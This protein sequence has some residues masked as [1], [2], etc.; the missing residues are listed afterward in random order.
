MDASVSGRAGTAANDPSKDPSRKAKSQDPGWKYGYW[1]DVADRNLVRCMLCGKDV[2]GGIKRLKQ[3][4]VGGYGD[5]TKCLK[6]TAKIAREMHEAIIRNQKRK[7][8]VFDNDYDVGHPQGDLPAELETRG[9][10]QSD[11][12]RPPNRESQ[13]SSSLTLLPSY[14]TSAK[15][16]KAVMDV[17]VRGPMDA[18]VKRNLE[19]VLAE[20]REFVPTLQSAFMNVGSH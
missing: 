1:P 3:H 13:A 8:E 20:D 2:K 9:Q 4:L 18:Y 5:V 7:P 17:Q 15:R 6:T 11:A 10:M 14:G 19:E 16:N 12:Y